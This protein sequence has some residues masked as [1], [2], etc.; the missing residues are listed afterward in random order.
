MWKK[1][2]KTSRATIDVNSYTYFKNLRELSIYKGSLLAAYKELIRSYVVRAADRRKYLL[3]A[4]LLR[5]NI[6]IIQ[7]RIQGKKLSYSKIVKGIGFYDT[8][9]SAL[10]REASLYA[11]K[12]VAIGI[13]VSA[14]L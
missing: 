4:R 14:A 12:V 10:L 7:G 3:K 8:F 2:E 1:D 9:I 6:A 5:Q 11:S 13:L